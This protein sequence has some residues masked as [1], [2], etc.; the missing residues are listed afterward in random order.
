MVILN[1]AIKTIQKKVFVFFEKIK[2]AIHFGYRAGS[3]WP[4]CSLIFFSVV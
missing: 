3:T 2:L 1:N 4:E